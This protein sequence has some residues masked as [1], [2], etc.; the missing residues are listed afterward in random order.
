MELPPS[1]RMLQLPLLYCTNILALSFKPSFLRTAISLP[2]YILLVLQSLYQKDHVYYGIQYPMAAL[3]LSLTFHYIDWI[4]LANPDKERWH[5]IPVSNNKRSNERKVIEN[6]IGI[7]KIRPKNENIATV[8]TNFSTRLWW[9]FRL[10]MTNRYVGWSNQVK[11][12]PVEFEAD[13][14]RW[15]F[16]LRKI[17]RVILMH[18]I[19]DTIQSYTTSTPHG[20]FRGFENGKVPVGF[21]DVSLVR[22]FLLTWGNLIN[23]YANL[24][25]ANT[26]C[27]IVAVVIGLAAPSDCP[28]AFG[29][30]KGLYTVRQTWSV[31][32]HQNCR[33]ICTAPSLFIVRDVLGLR[34]GSF[35]SK[36]AQLFLGFFISAIVH[37]AAAMLCH[38]SFD[39][40]DAAFAVFMAQA[41][42]IFI[43][44]HVI[45]F[46][47]RIGLRD[48]F[49]WR[50]VGYLWVVAWFGL[51][52]IPY[53][54]RGVSH[55]IWIHNKTHDYFGVGART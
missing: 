34:K 12:V 10:S 17:P 53:T 5:R 8:P 49:T 38:R 39:D 21:D 19:V 26:V 50:S 18:V 14:P 2:I 41:V 43:E 27:G 32:W 20:A 7:T 35:A 1:I 28:S 47:K 37:G 15:L 45:E 22:Q 52:V 36:Y 54:S 4:L 29:D 11:N 46:G 6:S 9:A 23:T 48:S 40:D 31:V 55:G 16:L 13:Y 44:D 42:A 3:S 25:M 33:R 30:L 51:S 24:E